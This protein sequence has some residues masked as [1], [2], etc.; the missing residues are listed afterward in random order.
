MK[1]INNPGMNIE[2]YSDMTGAC[3]TAAAA[4]AF[5]DRLHEM[6]ITFIAEMSR[7]AVDEVEDDLAGDLGDARSTFV[8]LIELG[9]EAVL[10]RVLGI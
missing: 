4:G 2:L 8:S 5:R 10:S 3:A 9:S 1:T 6:T 7:K